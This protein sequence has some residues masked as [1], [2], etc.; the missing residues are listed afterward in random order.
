MSSGEKISI[1][2]LSIL[3]MYGISRLLEFNGIGINMYGSYVVFY[4]FMLVS[5]LVLVPRLKV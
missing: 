1:L 5:S 2:G 4:V 3:L